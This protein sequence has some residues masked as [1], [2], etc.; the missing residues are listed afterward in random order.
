MERKKYLLI[1]L[2]L[3][4]GGAIFGQSKYDREIYDSYVRNDMARWQQIIK[5][6]ERDIASEGRGTFSYKSPLRVSLIN[7]YYGICG[8]LISQKESKQA[9][10]YI[11]KGELLIENILDKEPEN[12]TFIA[13]KAAFKGFRIGISN[14]K[15]VYL[16]VQSLNHAK[17]AM[18][19]DPENSRV[20]IEMGNVLYYSPSFA[21]GDRQ[22]G[23]ELYEKA[24]YQI[25]KSQSELHNWQYL[26]LLTSI[27]NAFIEMGNRKKALEYYNK[28]VSAEP[29]FIWIRQNLGPKINRM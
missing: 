21:G 24:V 1:F 17:R 28:T 12:A 11:K 9:M 16:G 15:A 18:A 3:L 8:W 2:I 6:A 22:K 27:T 19:L 26:S 4:I 10:E 14:F 23:L 13:Y 7:Y 20:L 5:M 29:A 25:E